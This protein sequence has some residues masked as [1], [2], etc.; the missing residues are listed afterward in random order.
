MVLSTAGQT[1]AYAQSEAYQYPDVS[2]SNGSPDPHS[3]LLEASGAYSPPGSVASVESAADADATQVS[4]LVSETSPEAD[5]ESEGGYGHVFS[6]IGSGMVDEVVNHPGRLVGSAALGLGAAVAAVLVAPEVAAAVAIGAGL[7]AAWSLVSALPGWIHNASV[8]ANPDDH[9]AAEV[10]DAEA[11]LRSLGAGTLDVAA[12]ALGAPI[13]GLVGNALRAPLQ[14]TAAELAAVIEKGAATEI[15]GNIT[16]GVANV[17]NRATSF[18]SPYLKSA[19]EAIGPAVKTA[20]TL[21][22]PLVN[23]ASNLYTA[24]SEAITGFGTQLFDKVDKV[25]GGVAAR[26]GD[27]KTSAGAFTGRVTEGVKS[28]AV[29]IGTDFA[30]L[31]VKGADK[32]G[33]WGAPLADGF[34]KAYLSASSMFGRAYAATSENVAAWVTPLKGPVGEFSATLNGKAMN[35]LDGASK[36]LDGYIVTVQQSP[37]LNQAVEVAQPYVK[38]TGDY[39]ISLSDDALGVARTVADRAGKFSNQTA[40]ASVEFAGKIANRAT[41]L[42]ERI[43][44]ALLLYGDNITVAQM[45]AMGLSVAHVNYEYRSS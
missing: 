25:S 41:L 42:N 8:A 19:N 16:S 10:N 20:A 22:Q 23:R 29:P 9:T 28:I 7:Y 27:W 12:S 2:E 13:G 33:S 36:K 26:A 34:G 14:A 18:V 3:K 37:Y 15:G 44:E 11:G 1:K 35:V 40:E 38:G 30:N 45:S 43:A 31:A 17:A 32:V 24:H 6:E 39:I 21:A 4:Q 5:S